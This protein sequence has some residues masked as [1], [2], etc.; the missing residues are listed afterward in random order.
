M[1]EE[2]GTYSVTLLFMVKIHGTRLIN[3]VIILAV[4]THGD[5][6]LTASYVQGKRKKSKSGQIRIVT[7]M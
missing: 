1:W 5:K 6:M 4:F 2:R 3:M 7:F